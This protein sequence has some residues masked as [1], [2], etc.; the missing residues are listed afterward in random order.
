[1]PPKWLHVTTLKHLITCE[2]ILVNI[3]GFTILIATG[4]GIGVV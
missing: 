1:M 3:T 2:I 4:M